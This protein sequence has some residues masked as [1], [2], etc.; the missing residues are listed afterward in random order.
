MFDGFDYV[1]LGHIHRAQQC[2]REWIRYSGTPLKYSFSEAN[3]QKTVTM[4]ELK[5][6]GE[7]LLS[8]MPLVPKHDM[9]EIRGT[10]AEL[11]QEDFY[12]ATTYP[13]DYTHITLTDEE[14]IPDALAKLRLI[15]HNLMKLDYDNRRT[16]HSVEITGAEDVQSKTPLEQFGELYEMQNG[17]SLSDEQ[18]AFLKK[19]I[20]EIWEDEP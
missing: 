15:Y 9:V 16:R 19:I 6:K 14:D 11:T 20:E 12:Q 13:T 3:D 8:F 7:L 4:V 5:E 18:T 10:F 1:A 2:G 17:Q